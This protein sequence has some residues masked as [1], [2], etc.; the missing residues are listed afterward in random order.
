ME[1]VLHGCWMR[2]FLLFVCVVYEVNN[3]KA[4]LRCRCKKNHFLF[5]SDIEVC[6]HSLLFYSP[7]NNTNV[8][9]D[10]QT[11]EVHT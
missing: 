8:V 5:L 10:I 7:V 2:L 4:S 3:V 9:C 6:M 1:R 11:L